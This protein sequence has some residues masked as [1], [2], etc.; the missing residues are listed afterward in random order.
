MLGSESPAPGTPMARTVNVYVA[1]SAGDGTSQLVAA[2]VRVRQVFVASSAAVATKW[3]TIPVALTSTVHDTVSTGVAESVTV[4]V[5][6]VG[7]AGLAA[8][9]GAPA[10]VPPAAP[11]VAGGTAA[12]VAVPVVPVAG[13]L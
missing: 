1:P 6:A 11:A 9:T 7:A 4:T 8:A 2:F 13:A 10:A 12:V 3:S 5:T